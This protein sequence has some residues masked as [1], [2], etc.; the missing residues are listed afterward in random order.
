[1]RS[2]QNSLTGGGEPCGVADTYQGSAMGA[3]WLSPFALTAR[4]L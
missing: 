1:M 3:G 2:A 4:I